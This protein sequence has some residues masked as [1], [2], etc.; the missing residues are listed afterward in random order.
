MYSA[1]GAGY[2]YHETSDR[3][4]KQFDDLARQN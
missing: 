2:E 1:G 3:K 4:Y